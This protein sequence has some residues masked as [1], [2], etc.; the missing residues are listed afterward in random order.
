VKPTK[1]PHASRESEKYAK[2]IASR[3]LILD[4]LAQSVGP[5]PHKKLVQALGIEDD[6]D[7]EALR[8]RLRAM[9]RDGQIHSN[10][11][12]AYAIVDKLDLV[13]GKIQG[14]RDGYGFVIAAEGD[15]VY[16]PSRQMRKVF[17]GDEVLARPAPTGV[18][19]RRD[20]VIVEVVAHNTEQL[21]GR[22]YF[23][24]GYG[25]VRPDNARLG[26]DVL[27]TKDNTM[28]ATHSQFVTVEITRQPSRDNLPMGKIIE[29]LGDHM[30]PGME[31]DVAIR[32]H[33]LPHEW[34]VDVKTEA[35]A[36]A[37]TVTARDK[38]NRI[39]CRKH[40]F[41]TID[42]EDAR[43]FDDA[44]FCE[45]KKSGGWR[46]YVAIA[47]V[48][49]YVTIG[50]ALDDEAQVRSTSVYFPDFVLPMLPEALSNGL[51]SLNPKLDRL[52][53]VCEMT[54]SASG[55]V[56]GYQFY[57]SVIYSHA[58]LT[59]TKVGEMLNAQQPNLALREEYKDVVGDIDE[60]HALYKVLR[61]T[62]EVRGAIDFETTETRILFDDDRKIDKIVPVVRNDAH[63]LIEECMLCANV[64]A[65]KFIEKH[66]LDGLFRVHN[67]PKEQKLTNLKT[68]LGA[69]GLS[70]PSSAPTPSDYQ[71]L[72]QAIADR[73]DSKIIQT[74]MLRS[75][76]QA[77][78][79]P[80]NQGHFGLAYDAYAHFT[81]PIRR[82]P[83]LL[84]HRAIRSI[85]RSNKQTA[86]VKRADGASVLS[87]KSIYPYAIEDMVMLGAHTS[88]A[89]RRADEATRDVVSWLKC[90][91]LQ[92]HVG[93][94]FQGVVTG[95]TNFGLFV[96]LLDVYVEG[97]IHI[98]GLPSDY[99]RFEEAHHRLVGERTNR[100]F[101]LGDVLTV[102]VASVKLDERKVD[103]E[104]VEDPSQKK[105]NDS[106]RKKYS[107]KA[108]GVN[109]PA[110]KTSRGSKT[111]KN[112]FS[113]KPKLKTKQSAA[114]DDVKLESKKPRKRNPSRRRKS[115]TTKPE[116]I[117]AV[118][119]K[120]TMK[121]KIVK[122]KKNIK[123]FFKS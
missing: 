88:M 108:T 118:D 68:F 4:M 36:L 66:E 121:D 47:D 13:R 59:Y 10:R 78:Y 117:V 81:S 2:P 49:H 112:K 93:D 45:A 102:Q 50:S 48:S 90:E 111:S 73:P 84:V 51:C 30:A 86:H 6:D 22:Y 65:A 17:H 94:I 33:D 31:I 72:L 98:T 104:L 106:R 11:K 109:K 37:Q 41:V 110:E 107:E 71:R 20:G 99:Y 63:K 95:V 12:K 64:S 61:A 120:S 35:A 29:V 54:I 55:K 123:N 116:P 28:G 114:G 27:V 97:L 87:K 53:L 80:D 82:Y 1:D 32:A 113:K 40:H 105:A 42:G 18:R 74:V 39:D 26:H 92:N 60:L 46:L 103:F 67:G 25:F 15:D 96:E 34:P 58:R 43:D 62:R 7:F 38:E 57:E 44:V 8:R 5:M 23:E 100:V 115:A 52:A 3:E 21:V 76:S 79:Q 91:Y 83:D 24:Q 75:L 77:M 89:E 14:H 56:S 85:I 119:S 101:S 19:G 70:L 9:E 122:M 69:L 16:L